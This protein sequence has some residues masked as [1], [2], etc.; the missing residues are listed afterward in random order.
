MI[1]RS[2][3]F[4]T[5][6]TFL[7]RT[8]EHMHPKMLI[9]PDYSFV[10]N[11]F[12]KIFFLC[13]ITASGGGGVKGGIGILKEKNNPLFVSSYRAEKRSLHSREG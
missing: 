2:G 13:C 9:K 4:Q 12:K 7:G 8:I 5:E 11:I 6:G 10:E 1:L 3:L